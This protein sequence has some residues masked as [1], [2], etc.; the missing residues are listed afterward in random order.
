MDDK[1]LLER[2]NKKRYLKRY[3][4]NNVLVK[5]LEHK[6]VAVEARIQ[7]VRSPSLSGM[8]RGGAPVTSADLI[9]EK[10]DLERRIKRLKSKGRDIRRETLDL[11]DDLDLDEKHADVLESFLIDGMDFAEI[12]DQ[13]GFTERHVIRIYSEAIDKIMLIGP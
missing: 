6:L 4:R 3:R 1:T 9:A 7:G 8:P 5:R 2:Q 13:M 12:A 11:I 10:V